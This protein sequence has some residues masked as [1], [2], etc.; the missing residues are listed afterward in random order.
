MDSF[1]SERNIIHFIEKTTKGLT[2]L[3][4]AARDEN[5]E[6]C[7]ALL[8]SG[9]SA[10]VR[11]NFGV[12][13]LH[14][15]ALNKKNGI[16]IVWHLTTQEKQDVK[17]KDVDGEEAIFYAVRVGNF[18]VAQILLE[19]REKTNNNLLH[20]CITQNRSD[21]VA[22]IIH[23]WN[24]SLIK[25]VDSNR[26][27]ALHLAA[28]FADLRVCKWLIAAGID[29][30]SNS[31]LGTALH[32][33]PLNKNHGLELVRF[34]VSKKL[35]L[36]KKSE[37]GFVPLDAALAEENIDIASEL[38]RLG[39]T[40][41][42]KD[43]NFLLHCVLVNKLNC[44]KF[45]HGFDKSLIRGEAALHIAAEFA[46]LEMCRWLVENGVRTDSLNGK[47]QTSI[48]HHVGYNKRHG[49]QLVRYFF[50]LGLDM[51]KQDFYDFTPLSYALGDKNFD[52]A[53]E[54]L[55]YGADFYAIND[56]MNI[57][58]V[59]IME[60]NL[61]GVQF[62]LSKEPKIMNSLGKDG[63]NALHIAAAF[64]DLKMCQWLSCGEKF[65][66][67]SLSKEMR[68]TVLHYVAM[69]KKFGKSLVPFF[70]SKV[71]NVNEKNI[72]SLSAF[73]VALYMENIAVAEE[74]LKA[75]ADMNLK[76]KR[77]NNVLQF[78]ARNN[79]IV[80]AKFVIGLNEGLVR[81]PTLGGV[82]ALHLATKTVDLEFCKFLV[83]KGAEIY[84][85]DF[86]ERSVLV[87]VPRK[88]KEKRNFLSLGVGN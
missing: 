79:K 44:V 41:H 10:E 69:N 27:N 77:N 12:T 80:S 17:Q 15:A 74:L 31:F 45:I 72:F 3:M 59:C 22:Q 58:H 86:L 33:A 70:V 21:D 5:L 76:S 75:G 46:D 18:R 38:L 49:T 37:S 63:T 6:S 20:F 84:A 1:M 73:Y 83:E 7:L 65:D 60:N 55:I 56:G 62:V 71:V 32:R 11:T 47:W 16:E 35:D 78:C 36:N 87:Y 24:P 8:K 57:F 26:R 34:F 66:V 2:L 88:N 48:L 42:I 82:T 28:Q 30:S 29:V 64:A 39:A 23:A 61:E 67:L 14:F 68:N 4:I 13:P 52:V 9:E 81:E 25:E 43:H 51:N 85:K 54:M 19:L 40:L 50:H 53:E